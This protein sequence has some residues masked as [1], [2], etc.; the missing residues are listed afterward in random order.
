VCKI[1]R[2]G[3]KEVLSCK[4]VNKTKTKWVF[5]G[6]KIKNWWGED[7]SA[8]FKSELDFKEAG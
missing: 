3:E 2:K 7:E 6:L 1:G 5:T 4:R 8:K